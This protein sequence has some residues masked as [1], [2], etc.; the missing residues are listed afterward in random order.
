MSQKLRFLK[1][2]AKLLYHTAKTCQYINIF[3]LFPIFFIK[4]AA[5][6]K[7][8]CKDNIHNCQITA[9]GG[10]KCNFLMRFAI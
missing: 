8:R 5:I 4:K 9:E 3:F 10:R 2:A 1:S 7:N 6:F